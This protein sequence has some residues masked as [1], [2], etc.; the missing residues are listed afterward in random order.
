MMNDVYVL[1]PN[2]QI[3]GV[4]D[5]HA[6]LIW[7]Q[8]Y[9]EIGDCELYVPA[10]Q[11]NLE[12]LRKNNYLFRLDDDMVCIIKKVVL[13]TDPDDGNYLTVTGYDVKEWL[14]QRIIWG[15]LTSN[16]L[17][18]D[19]I[20]MMVDSSLG[21]SASNER[22]LKDGTGRPMFFLGDAV[23]F[24]E[25]LSEQVSYKNIGEKVRDYCQKYG[26]GYKV[27]FDFTNAKFIFSLYKGTDR[28]ASVVFSGNYENLRETTYIEDQTNMGNVALVAG[29]GEG[30]E[31]KIAVAGQMQGLNRYELYV[32][33]KDIST[34]VSWQTLIE[35]F[36][37]VEDGGK[38]YIFVDSGQYFYKMHELYVQILDDNQ[39]EKLRTEYPGGT[40]VTAQGQVYYYLTEVIIADLP[41]PRDG[42]FSETD[43]ATIRNLIYDLYLL[44][45]GLEDLAEYGDLT[46]FDGTVEPNTTFVF[47]EDYFLGDIVTVE[48]EYGITVEA[49]I[50]EIVEV[51]DDNGYYVEP[52]FEYIQED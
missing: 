15:M 13:E 19:F 7:A 38:G 22:K 12:L 43:N 26:W 39:L 36:P 6:S 45:R 10:N 49:R 4:I 29:E 51:S 35:A 37:L 5:S 2:L 25:I 48:N 31:R 24:D 21:E 33:A 16:G 3:A 42:A 9:R 20:R 32:D 41:E 52:R 27:T 8:R 1:N 34:T 30:S 18:E 11:N 17:A 47:K 40:V 44:A 28:S 23:G 14:D 50:V 46:S